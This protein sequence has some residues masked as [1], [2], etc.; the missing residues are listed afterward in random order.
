MITSFRVGAIFEIKDQATIVVQKLALSMREL[1]RDTALVRGELQSISSIRI[2][3]VATRVATLAANMDKLATASTAAGSA[4][5]AGIGTLDAG[6][7]TA[8]ASARALTAQ[9]VAAGRAGAAV[10]RGGG[11]GARP[12]GPPP[13]PG[14][15]GRGHG[16]GGMHFSR[17]GFRTPG[18][19]HVSVPGSPSGLA[20][21]AGGYGVYEMME[22][23][24]EPLH[25]RAMLRLLGIDDATIGAMESESRDIAVKVPGSGYTQN[26]KTMGELYSIVG[27]QGAMEIAPKLAEIDRVQSIVGGKGKDQGS[28]YT[29]TRATELMGQLTDPKTHQIDIGR[30]GGILDN[31]SR[32]SIATHGKITP[33]EWL[34]YAKQAGPASGNLTEDGLYTTAAVIQ[35][36]GGNRAG[37]AASAL[38]RQFAGGVMT[39]S[40]ADELKRIGIFKEGDYT[41]ERGGHVQFKNDAAKE[42]VTKLS[43]DPLTAMVDTLIPALES[44]GISTP[45]ELSKEVYKIAGTGP[46]QREMYEI[47]RG[48]EQIK[49]ERER[50]KGALPSTAAVASMNANDPEA[51][52]SAFSKAFK[53]LLGAVGGPL[54]TAAIPGM[55]SLTNVFNRLAQIAS[56]H[57]KATG[58]VGSM[59]AGAV[60]GGATGFG[61]GWLGGPLGAGTGALIGGAAGAGYGLWN[62]L[63]SS[64]TSGAATGAQLGWQSGLPLGTVLGGIAG[65]AWGGLLGGGGAAP[66]AVPGLP[67]A[68]VTPPG[69]NVTHIDVGGLTV[70]AET[71]DPRGLA[72][73]ILDEINSL[74]SAGHLHNL[75]EAGSTA[76]SPYVTGVGP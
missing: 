20:V 53:D 60:A 32:I 21:A 76:S 37:T 15:G 48:R 62:A 65:G 68:G 64:V 12:P 45:E 59:A 5:A 10:G 49:Q 41:V 72:T 56:A 22:A 66:A 58:V 42:F 50:A 28:A 29:L 13:L 70:K 67:G 9:L 73:K 18:H 19:G 14:G 57:E 7:T 24:K 27:A 71:D 46:S 52:G 43:R 30:F 75:G 8:L 63:P 69:G 35:A 23:A 1:A 47:I 16:R 54:M 25:Q 39:K 4:A 6:L 36:M 17:V 31:M 40:K 61:I 26:M 44:H 3:S 38:Q 74:I 51:A 55:V 34:N 33:E 2:G 11:G